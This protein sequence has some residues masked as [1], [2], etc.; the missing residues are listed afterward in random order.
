MAADPTHFFVSTNGSDRWSGTLPDPA[1]DGSDGPFATLTRARDAIRGMRHEAGGV[2]TRPVEVRVRDGTYRFEEALRLS[3]GDAGTADCPITYA[4]F[5]G[6]RPVLSGGRV[7]TEW[8]PFR[9]PILCADLPEG[10]AGRLWF[11]QLFCNGE[12]MV[13]ARWPKRDPDNPLYGGWAFMEE[14]LREDEQPPQ[15]FRFEADVFPHRWADPR[16]AEVFVFPGKCWCN[17]IIPIRSVDWESRTIELTRPVLPSRY[18]LGAATHFLDGNRFFVENN[19]EDLTEPG[20][21]CLDA[22]TGTLYF[23]PPAL[24]GA[25]GPADIESCEVTVPVTS[26]IVQMI[27]HPGA[28]VAHI[29]IRGFTFT[30]TQALWPT[31]EAYYKTPNAGQAVHLERC[32]ECAV[33]DNRFVRVGG[34]A[35]RLQNENARVRVTG[36]EIEEPGAYGIFVGAFQRGF[37]RHDPA[38]GDLPSPSEWHR[39]RFD[40]DTMAGAWP[41]SRGHV[42]ANNHIH[43]VGVIEKHA[44]GIAFFGVSAVDNLVAHNHIHH[45]PRFAIGIFSGFGR[46]T[47]EYNE[48]HDVSRETC[49]TGAI[50]CNRWYTIPGHPE[51][52]R[53]NII[54]FNRVRDVIGCGAYGTPAETIGEDVGK[55]R[56][57]VPYYGWAI[58]FDNAPM[59]V[60]VYGNICARNTLGGIMISHYARNV[61]VEN[62]ILVDAALSQVYLALAGAVSNVRFE[63]NIVCYR[64]PGAHYVRLN[65]VPEIRLPEAIAVFNHNLVFHAGDG[66]PAINGILGEA[67][68]RLGL[69]ATATPTFA[70][71]RKLGFD[72]DSVFEDP[73]FVDPENDDYSLYPDSPALEL[74]FEPIDVSRIGLEGEG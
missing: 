30:E 62:N 3:G 66:E 65:C 63:R 48:V 16:Q 57:W 32:E 53:G 60:E 23:H 39:D 50:T 12:R 71:W 18:T 73:R 41:V 14:V 10:R 67:A 8:R 13:R 17:D 33:E 34:D 44:S 26:R 24:S 27:G 25:E 68:E 9:G 28:P 51:L 38:S 21:W 47:V 45:T 37:C 55:D 56:V 19:L 58:Y 11:R 22:D 35:V 4:A 42:I 1:A 40:H 72:V 70:D 2:L 36:N 31:P 49:D 52:A 5:E 74:G 7:I 54:R 20:E 6:E 69:T 29:T 59:D 43:H 46:L 64:E 61:K 15:R